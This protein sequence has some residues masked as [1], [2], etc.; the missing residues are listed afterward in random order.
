MGQDML[1][2]KSAFLEFCTRAMI[3]LMLTFSEHFIL[4]RV[5]VNLKSI[6]GTV[7][8]RQEYRLDGTPVHHSMIL[9]FSLT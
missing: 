4:I 5:S 3:P 9:L 8:M 7:G 6:P 1:D 2:V